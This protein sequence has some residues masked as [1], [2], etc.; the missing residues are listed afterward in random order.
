MLDS[1]T[2]PKELRRWSLEFPYLHCELQW[3]RHVRR[4]GKTA[5]YLLD[6]S[7]LQYH[8]EICPGWLLLDGNVTSMIASLSQSSSTAENS[9]GFTDSAEVPPQPLTD[10][11]ADVIM[12][13]GEPHAA[14]GS[15]VGLAISVHLNGRLIASH[16]MFAPHKAFRRWT[17]A[18]CR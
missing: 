10:D 13:D 5:R 4:H 9:A 16:R 11:D 1:E 12:I 2:S 18:R 7:K 15:M 8:F 6:E 17:L 14:M 3:L